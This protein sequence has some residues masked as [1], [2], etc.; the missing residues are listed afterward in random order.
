MYR[1]FFPKDTKIQIFTFVDN[2]NNNPEKFK[3]D[4]SIFEYCGI[5]IHSWKLTN[6]GSGFLLQMKW[7]L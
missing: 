1:S 7:G 6:N 5:K 3:K 4:F 2:K